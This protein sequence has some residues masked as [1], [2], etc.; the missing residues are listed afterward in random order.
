MKIYNRSLWVVA[1]VAML[2]IGT[3]SD[4]EAKVKKGNAKKTN[5]TTGKVSSKTTKKSSSN[6][7]TFTVKGVKFE[8]VPV[9]GGSYKMLNRVGYDEYEEND[10]TLNSFYI[11][12]T[13]V[14]Q[15]LWK[16]VMDEFTFDPNE[17][18]NDKWPVANVSHMSCDA[19]VYTLNKLTGMHFRLPTSAE[20]Q[21]AARGGNKSKHYKYAGGNDI[22]EVAWYEGNSGSK[23]HNVATKKANELGIYDM[24][25]NVSEWCAEYDDGTRSTDPNVPGRAV[26]QATFYNGGWNNTAQEC[27]IKYMDM[28]DGQSYPFIGLRLALDK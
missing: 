15:E 10:V 9:D 17:F 3:T 4:V 24:S 23:P 5:A 19:F 14:T 26:P 13:E 7:L 6:N 28:N 18:K 22:N 12:Q 21:F 25:G 1:I 20:W 11:G 16:A 2:L 27:E 8:M